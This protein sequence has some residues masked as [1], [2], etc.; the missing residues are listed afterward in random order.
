MLFVL[1]INL[2]VFIPRLPVLLLGWDGLGIV[3][4]ALVVYYQ[5]IKSLGAGMITVLTNRIGD[6]IIL[7]S[8]GLLVLQG[9]WFIICMWDFHLMA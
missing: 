6:V 5:N 9:H 3:S 1:S 7:I 8:V 4:F 2:L